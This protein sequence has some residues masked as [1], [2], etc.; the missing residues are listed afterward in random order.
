MIVKNRREILKF[1]VLLSFIQFFAGC[2][3]SD[4]SAISKSILKWIS[5]NVCTDTQQGDAHLISK[6]GKLFLIDTGHFS[7]SKSN[8][9]PF[10][11]EQK[12]TK[13]DAVIISHAHNDHYGGVKSLFENNISIEKLYINFPTKEQ[14]SK[15]WWGGKY[16][17]LVDI[18]NIAKT[19]NTKVLPINQ[20]DKFVFSD[21]SYIEVLY[22]YDGINTPVG[23]TDINDMS[24]VM[25]IYDGTNRFLLTGDLNSKIGAYLAENA[26]NIEADILKVPHHGAEGL[27]PNSFFDKVNPKAIIVTSPKYLW[28]SQ[29]DERVRNLSRDRGYGTYVNGFHGHITVISNEN[30]YKILTQHDSVKICEE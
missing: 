30:N 10:L 11:K 15:E 1:I 23:E 8:F 9:I 6:N 18:K 5:I 4:K 16:Q 7:A 20:G 27:A 13:I 12:I 24:A 22:V 21:N 2:G 26:T 14:M 17:D 28:C 25:M 19:N 29:R 3:D